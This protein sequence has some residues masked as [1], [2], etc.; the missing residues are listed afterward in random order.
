[1]QQNVGILDSVLR[2]L[3]GFALLF[4]A[5]IV[6]P[7]LKWVAYAGFV[8]LAVTGFVGKCPLY[9]LLGLSTCPRKAAA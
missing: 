9:R 7:P 5:F 6:P 2:V 3:L 4:T 8:I 1:M